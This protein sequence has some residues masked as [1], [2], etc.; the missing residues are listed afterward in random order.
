MQ[1]VSETRV[2]RSTRICRERALPRPG[3]VLVNPGDHV[4]PTQIVARANVP[5]DF[6]ILPVAR[7]LGVS[8]SEA[9]AHLEVGLGETVHRGD[10]IA[11]RGGFLGP[12][13]ESPIDGVMTAT[14]GGRVLIEA[15]PAPFELHAHISGTV[16]DVA[17]NQI[18]SIET[19][20]A[21]IEAFWGVGGES[22][23][24]VKVMSERPNESLEADII[25]PSCHGSVL[26]AG[27]TRDRESLIRAQDIEARGI[28][29]G[30][31]V[32]ELLPILE[33]L[34]F[35]VIV[36]AGF[37]EVAMIDEIF[38]LLR[39]N[40]GR[41]ASIGGQTGREWNG[42]RPE[43]IIP[44]PNTE[45]PVR[46]R[47]QFGQLAPGVRVRIIRAPH[48]GSVGTV[49]DIPRYARRIATG[50]RVRCAEV[51]IGQGEPVF[52]PLVNLDILG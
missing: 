42:Q 24:V 14:G 30:G 6:R 49:L 23:G 41:E 20:G 35:P 37:R 22:V 1:Y 25:D 31:L 47:Q 15:P 45:P 46:E 43:I 19:P 21:L 52:V 2:S 10:V 8:A 17:D 33:S 16:L 36:T 44:R 50:T 13:V 34:P 7:L 26:V 32:P 27:V 40:E 28:V 11:R 9:E 51:D 38:D 18:I 5:G 4:E 3:E 39:E 29:T 12:S 48:A